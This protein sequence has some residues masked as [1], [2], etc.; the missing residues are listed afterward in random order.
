VT[1][2]GTPGCN[3]RAPS[4]RHARITAPMTKCR[5]AR[6][7]SRHRRDARSALFA[8]RAM[9]RVAIREKPC[10]RHDSRARSSHV[11]TMRF[12]ELPL[13]TAVA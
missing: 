9:H 11:I 6:I 13:G 2:S 7:A 8:G 3:A 10:S 5:P 12:N 1:F 4:G